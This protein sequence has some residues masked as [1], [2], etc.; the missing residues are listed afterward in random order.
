MPTNTLSVIF[1]M[2]LLIAGSKAQDVLN[3]VD[4][5]SVS[6]CGINPNDLNALSM[7][8]E[9]FPVRSGANSS[10]CMSSQITAPDWPNDGNGNYNIWVST[11]DVPAGCSINFYHYLDSNEQHNPD[12][13]CR[14]L[15]CCGN[16]CNK[17]ITQWKR[18]LE[19]PYKKLAKDVTRVKRAPL[20]KKH[21]EE[22]PSKRDDS[23]QFVPNETPYTT[24]GEQTKV[25]DIY[26]CPPKATCAQTYSWSNGTAVTDGYST[27][28][29]V[30]ASIF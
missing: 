12:A 3:T 27:T 13:A 4:I 16:D 7:E 19:M 23:C 1:S 17:D 11:K 14:S 10:D 24:Y 15:Y 26:T 30:T 2:G 29:T 8:L 28:T 18:E 6:D 21:I 22:S 9:V 5:Y 25:G 20:L